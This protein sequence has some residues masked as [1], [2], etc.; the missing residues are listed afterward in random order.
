MTYY[1]EVW[2]TVM[3]LNKCEFIV[4][5]N[6]TYFALFLLYAYN[7][8]ILTCK[9]EYNDHIFKINFMHMCHYISLNNFINIITYFTITTMIMSILYS[10]YYNCYIINVIQKL[11]KNMWFYI[12]TC[13][14]IRKIKI[15][16][17]LNHKCINIFYYLFK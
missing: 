1:K 6:W 10:I 17:I 7:Y 15:K 16:S 5:F 3:N 14:K 8:Y 2:N 12:K 9:N 11:N 4:L 13:K